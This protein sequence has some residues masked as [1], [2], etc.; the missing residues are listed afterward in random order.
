MIAE[1]AVIL[2]VIG[3]TLV[4]VMTLIKWIT[5]LID[6]F[7]LGEYMEG[8]FFL[9]LGITIIGVIILYFD[10]MPVS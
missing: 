9:G 7:I 6:C 10:L 1:I 4:S 3:L 2:I 5:I 8:I